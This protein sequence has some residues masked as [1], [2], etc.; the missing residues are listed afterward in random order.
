MTEDDTFKALGKP[1]LSQLDEILDEEFYKWDEDDDPL[2]Q[3]WTS[4]END[5][6]VRNNWTMNEYWKVS[7]YG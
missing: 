6:I 1:T 7:N 3:T 5:L 2:K 4:L